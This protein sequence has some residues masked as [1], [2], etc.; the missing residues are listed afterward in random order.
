MALGGSFSIESSVQPDSG[1]PPSI[2]RP[3]PSSTRPRSAAPT[4]TRSG[5]PVDTT[6]APAPTPDSDPSGRQLTSS[7][8]TATTS[9]GTASGPIPMR[10]RSPTRPGTPVTVTDSPTTALTRPTTCGRA[11]ARSAS[12]RALML[13]AWSLRS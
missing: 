3:S 5:E 13:P 11:A 7:P 8:E 6:G 4:G 1:G 9:A 12:K 10:T 2:G